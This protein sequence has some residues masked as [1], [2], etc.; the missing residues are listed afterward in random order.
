MAAYAGV[1]L[2]IN[3]NTMNLVDRFGWNGMAIAFGAIAVVLLLITF[4]F[5]KERSITGISGKS[6]KKIPWAS[7][8]GYCSGISTL[9]LSP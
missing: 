9:Y 1:V 2:V 4:F 7:L 3:Y 5:T 8:S 6:E